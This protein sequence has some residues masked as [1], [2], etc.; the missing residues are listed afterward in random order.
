MKTIKNALQIIHALY[1]GR[2]SA[3]TP[4]C[5]RFCP[6]RAGGFSALQK[7][8]FADKSPLLMAYAAAASPRNEFFAF[9]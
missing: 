3:T 5:S 6:T 2:D 7:V 4:H 8:E 1:A 9:D